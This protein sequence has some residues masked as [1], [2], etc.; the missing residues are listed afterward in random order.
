[1]TAFYLAARYGRRLELADYADQLR[2]LGHQVTSRWLLG[3]HQADDLEV[4]TGGDVHQ[5]PE[6][7]R[8]FAEE[9]VEDV[10]FADV[11]VAFSEPP[12][13]WASRGGRHVEFGM[14]LGWVLAGYTTLEGHSRRLVVIGQRENVFHCLREVAVFPDWLSF[15]GTVEPAP[16]PEEAIR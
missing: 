12:H 1:M 9:G 14:V 11:I 10:T 3:Q 15:L 4:D 5:V 8:R 13:S 7:A 16:E 6:L 2:A